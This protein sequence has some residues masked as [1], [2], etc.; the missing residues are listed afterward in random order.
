MIFF[1]KFLFI[2]MPLFNLTSSQRFLLKIWDSSD[3]DALNYYYYFIFK[4]NL[5]FWNTCKFTGSVKIRWTESFTLLSV[6]NPNGNILQ[7]RSTIS[8]PG[9]CHWH[10]P[11]KKHI[12]QAKYP[13]SCSF[14]VSPLSSPFLYFLNH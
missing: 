9:Y 8:Q 5:L 6:S 7:N 12:L 13:S 3:D 14:I 2:F 1:S 10:S 11:D 4:V